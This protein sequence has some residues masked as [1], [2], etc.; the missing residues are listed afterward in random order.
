MRLAR[1]RFLP[2]TAGAAVL[3]VL[4]RIANGQAYPARPVR[5][6]VGFPAGGSSDVIGRLMAQ[7]LSER[8]GRPF[9]FENRPGAG[10]LLA[11]SSSM[12]PRSGAR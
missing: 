1:R 12:K 11:S 5:I 10:S 8:L 6:I 9:V 7:W 2:L 4:P 3:P